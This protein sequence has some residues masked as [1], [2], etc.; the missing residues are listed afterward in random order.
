VKSPIAAMQEIMQFKQM[1]DVRSKWEGGAMSNKEMLV[2]HRKEEMQKFRTRL[3]LGKNNQLKE[4]YEKAVQNEASTEGT[5]ANNAAALEMQQFRADKAK[6]FRE[7]FEKGEITRMPDDDEDLE[8]GAQEDM[9]SIQQPRS[10]VEKDSA[11][12]ECAVAK[13]SR[14]LF[15]EM[16]QSAMKQQGTT[17]GS[18]IAPRTPEPRVNRQ[19]CTVFMS[20][21]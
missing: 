15:K 16:D 4:M 6:K 17:N 13:Q 11:V 9:K 5:C 3:C 8:Q 19:V 18:H 7:M 1:E 12:F 10:L 20:F 21:M 2:G 14:S